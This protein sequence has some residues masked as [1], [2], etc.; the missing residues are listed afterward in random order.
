M[1]DSTNLMSVI[2][3]GQFIPAGLAAD[4]LAKAGQ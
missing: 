1:A 4:V 3:D 2:K